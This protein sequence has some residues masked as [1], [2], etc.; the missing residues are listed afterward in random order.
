M[1]R[2]VL[3]TVDVPTGLSSD[4]A[5]VHPSLLGR[6]FTD[7]SGVDHGGPVLTCEGWFKSTGGGLTVD[8]DGRF[9]E[10]SCAVARPIACC[11]VVP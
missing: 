11:A 2:E 9:E 3:E 1:S 8:S 5:W 4:A 10:I 6:G 7:A